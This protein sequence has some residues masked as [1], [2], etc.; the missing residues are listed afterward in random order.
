MKTNEILKEILENNPELKKDKEKVKKI[1]KNLLENNPKITATKEFK[2]QLKN[3]LE[4]IIQ[5]E[6]PATNRIFFFAGLLQVFSIF[7]VIGWFYYYFWWT[8]FFHSNKDINSNLK[9]EPLIERIEEETISEELEEINTIFSDELENIINDIDSDIEN[10]REIQKEPTL[11]RST[12]MIE[13]NSEKQPEIEPAGMNIQSLSEESEENNVDNIII[14]DNQIIDLLWE[15]EIEDSW[16]I[17]N[18]KW[19]P[20]DLMDWGLLESEDSIMWDYMLD[21]YP[22]NLDSNTW[23]LSNSGSILDFSDFCNNN[24]WEI[25][26]LEEENICI[27]DQKRSIESD[28]K[29]WTCT[30]VEIK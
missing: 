11:F 28:Y 21:D 3:R 19:L 25:I 17:N 1:I 26:T 6:S 4:N 13:D 27:I 5:M 14:E 10:N 7:F 9:V 2:D 29:N 15:P 24:L 30:F 16:E 22:E 20:S 18:F 23:S 12:R 8:T